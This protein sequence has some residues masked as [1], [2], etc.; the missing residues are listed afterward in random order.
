M[1]LGAVG[2]TPIAEIEVRSVEAL[3]KS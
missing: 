3:D 2:D 1:V